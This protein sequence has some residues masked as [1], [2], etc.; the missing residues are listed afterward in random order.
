[1]LFG[2]VNE[3]NAKDPITYEVVGGT[4]TIKDC[5]EAASGVLAI[6]SIHKGKPVTSIGSWAFYGCSRLTRVT[7]PDSVTGIGYAAFSKC[8]SLKDIDVGEGNSE[9]SS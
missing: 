9:Y 8:S 7:I 1:M 4:V 2:G 5:K 6:P 3:V